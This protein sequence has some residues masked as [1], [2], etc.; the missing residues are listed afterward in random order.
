[1]QLQKP[2]EI[3]NSFVAFAG[4]KLYCGTY[5]G[6][7]DYQSMLTRLERLLDVA[8]VDKV[9][10]VIDIG[11]N[12][13]FYTKMISEKFGN[14][15]IYAFE[16][17]KRA[18]ECLVKNVN[19]LHNVKTYNLAVSNTNGSIRMS[20]DSNNSL[21]SK[22]DDSGSEVV[23]TVSLD[24][25]CEANRIE[26]ID[27]LKIDVETF[28]HMVLAGAKQTLAKTR[29]LMLEVTLEGNTN[30]TI[31]RLLGML[32]SDKYNFQLV[33][34]RNYADVYEGKV[35]VMDTVFVNTAMQKI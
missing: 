1:M 26:V 16:P 15:T 2:L 28:E 5:W 14:P 18:Y 20:F 32:Y 4:T 27:I 22:Q 35:T 8:E 25:F 11:A 30:Y 17:V 24:S 23:D 12:V 7:A 21:I 10:T 6:L 29:Y 31:S 13:G 33:S 9:S 3:G 19:G 34:F